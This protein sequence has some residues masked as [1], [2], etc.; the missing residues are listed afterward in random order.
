MVDSRHLHPFFQEAH[1]VRLQCHR[2]EIEIRGIA[3]QILMNAEIFRH[4]AVS[5][6]PYLT[7][8]LCNMALHRVVELDRADFK[9]LITQEFFFDLRRQ[10]M[11]QRTRDIRF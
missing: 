4:R 10:Q 7:L 9:R 2:Q 5:A 11:R 3:Q 1:A 6:H 8:W